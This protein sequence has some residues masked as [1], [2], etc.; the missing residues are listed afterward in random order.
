MIGTGRTCAGRRDMRRSSVRGCHMGPRM[1]RQMRERMRMVVVS[2]QRRSRV[3]PPVS[4]AIVIVVPAPTSD[5][6]ATVKPRISGTVIHGRS[7]LDPY[8]DAPHTAK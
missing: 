3:D 6:A 2:V 7:G 4:V 8:T 5:P 1:V